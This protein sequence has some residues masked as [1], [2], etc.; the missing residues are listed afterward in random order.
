MH[1]GLFLAFGAALCW[2]LLNLLDKTIL[3]RFLRNP[4]ALNAAILALDLP[5]GLVAT[6]LTPASFSTGELVR[7]SLG[8]LAGI[9]G[10]FFYFFA[11]QRDHVSRVV[12]L[13]AVNPLLLALFGRIF[14]HEQLPVVAYLGITLIVLGAWT[15]QVRGSVW[16]PLRSR[17]LGLMLV[18]SL[19]WTTE[20]VLFKPLLDAHGTL[21]S[22]ARALLVSGIVGVLL[23]LRFHREIASAART[24]GRRLYGLLVL[25]EALNITAF[26]T[27][28]FAVSVWYAS[29]ASAASSVQYLFVFILALI[30]ARRFPDIFKD[31]RGLRLNARKLLAIVAVIVGVILLPN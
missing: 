23:L 16:S 12:P 26:V 25:D 9:T 31:E 27:Y 24:V 3:E 14:L 21:P 11:L 10:A 18:G 4:F 28:F 20:I 19:G 6:L 13:F 1:L 8:M 2:S 15:I 29:L 22:F 7:L 17:S 30:L 5:V